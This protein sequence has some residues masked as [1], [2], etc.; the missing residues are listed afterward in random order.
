MIAIRT[1]PFSEYL[2][3]PGVHWSALN[4]MRTSP[5]AY[6][7]AL[8]NPKEDTPSMFLGRSLHQAVLEP[9]K[10]TPCVWS[11]GKRQG[12]SWD[13]FSALYAGEP[14]LTEPEYWKINAMARAVRND[15][16]VLDSKI[17]SDYGLNEQSI[18]WVDPMTGLECKGRPDRIVEIDGKM[19]LIDL[20]STRS[21]DRYQFGRSA[22]EYGYH[23]QMAFYRHGL[24]LCCLHGVD[25]VLLVAVESSPP[26]EVGV[27]ELGIDEEI[28]AGEIEYRACLD[29]LKH[30]LATNEWPGRYSAVQTV[31]FPSYLF[32]EEEE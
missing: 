25:R 19:C 10:W 20:K 32:S 27:F 8:D 18:F 26:Y 7:Y 11:G 17:F 24:E 4:K 9:D 31:K 23:C 1:I 15:P 12:R 21:I 13:E 29:K 14:I 22:L 30:C 2:S 3:A 28:Y 5:A 16:V 6:K